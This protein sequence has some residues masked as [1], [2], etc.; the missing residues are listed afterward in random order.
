MKKALGTISLVVVLLLA[1][2]IFVLAFI[3]FR[4]LSQPLSI[5]TLPTVTNDPIQAAAAQPTPTVVSAQ[6]NGICSLAGSMMIL[7]LGLSTETPSRRITADSIRLV[8]IDIDQNKV[9]VFALPRDLVLKTPELTEKYKIVESQL[10][11]IYTVVFYAEKVTSTLQEAGYKATQATAQVIYDTFE[12]ASD[13][14]ITMDNEV[15]WQAI[16]ILGGITVQVGKDFKAWDGEPYYGLVIPKGVQKLNG[17]QS[18]AYY[19]TRDYSP[20]EWDRTERQDAVFKGLYTQVLSV[21]A[22]PKIPEMY[23][24]FM[25][26][27]VTDLSP[28]QIVS[29]AC[30]VKEFPTNKDRLDEIPPEEVV[31]QSDASFLLKDFEKTRHQIQIFLSGK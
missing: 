14:Y 2:V 16:D 13:H 30:L 5:N 9:Y 26:R 27:I 10:G 19:V 20:Q 18:H 11:D 15:M 4:P 28:A 23:V 24:T 29:M 21:A 1:L 12:I 7:N 31:I 22:L 25:D 6:K 3:F 17:L 8:R